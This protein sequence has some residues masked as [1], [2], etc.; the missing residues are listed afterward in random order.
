MPLATLGVS[1]GQFEFEFEFDHEKV[2]RRRISSAQRFKV[3]N[4]RVATLWQTRLM[5]LL[6]WQYNR[7]IIVKTLPTIAG[8]GLRE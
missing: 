2:L 3:F 6:Y 1:V 7:P 5:A 4:A 8:L